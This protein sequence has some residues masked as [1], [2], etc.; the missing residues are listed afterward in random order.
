M[1]CN[2]WF[3]TTSTLGLH[4]VHGKLLCLIPIQIFCYKT[5]FCSPIWQC[6]YV[7]Y[8]PLKTF[9]DWAK[10]YATWFLA[11]WAFISTCCSSHFLPLG[12]MITLWSLMR[13][14]QCPTIMEHSSPPLPIWMSKHWKNA[15]RFQN[16]WPYIICHICWISSSS[17]LL[18]HFVSFGQILEG[19][20]K[21][22]GLM[23]V[24]ILSLSLCV[25]RW[26]V[27]WTLN[28]SPNKH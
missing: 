15:L 9:T 20:S 8:C 21:L 22:S 11:K 12:T 17:V 23:F 27:F 14:T 25:L 28:S 26:Q 24:P 6:C 16:I 7:L 2:S 4:T 3:H 10:G 5:R 13:R 18:M 19:H 1:L